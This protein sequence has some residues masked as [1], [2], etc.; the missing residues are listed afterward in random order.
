[1]ARIRKTELCTL[2]N[3]DDVNEALRGMGDYDRRIEAIS[4]DMQRRI[5]EIKEDCA[6]VAT[7]LMEARAG[8][9]TQV[10]LYAKA[11][12]AEFRKVRT[13]VLTFGEFG[14]RQSTSLRC[15]TSPDSVA[16]VLEKLRAREMLDCVKCVPDTINRAVLRT[17]DADAVE[18]VGCEL[19]VSDA[20]FCVPTRD[21]LSSEV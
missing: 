7:P 15:P 19:V 6:E 16:E 20:F 18:D 9:E 8:L 14:F 1:M 11:R 2:M 12:Y 4:A 10:G 21:E 5:N 17:Y 3:L 13:K